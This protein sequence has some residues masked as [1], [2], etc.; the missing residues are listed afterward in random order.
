MSTNYEKL[1]KFGNDLWYLLTENGIIFFMNLCFVILLINTLA[2]SKSKDEKIQTYKNLNMY[3]LAF[4]A[5]GI[6]TFFLKILFKM[7]K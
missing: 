5:L 7:N 1:V 3:S 6:F 4:F 2:M